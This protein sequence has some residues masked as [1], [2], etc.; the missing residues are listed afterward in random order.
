L[1]AVPV[2]CWPTTPTQQI[3]AGRAPFFSLLPRVIFWTGPMPSPMR[4]GAAPCM[5]PGAAPCGP[6]P[7]APGVSARAPPPLAPASCLLPVGSCLLSAACCCT[8]YLIAAGSTQHWQSAGRL[9][10]RLRCWLLAAGTSRFFCFFFPV[11]GSQSR[12]RSRPEPPVPHVPTAAPQP[13]AQQ[14][15]AHSPQCPQTAARRTPHERGRGARGA[16]RAPVRRASCV[17]GVVQQWCVVHQLCICI[18]CHACHVSEGLSLVHRAC[19]RMCMCMW[20]VLS[21]CVA[22]GL[23]FLLVTI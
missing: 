9:G 2:G 16:R 1:M 3:A 18:A 15:A 4:H 7:H 22:E 17:V 21:V 8:C 19:A 23:S 20:C 14:P 12:S 5:R 11:P 13:T 6:M 10:S